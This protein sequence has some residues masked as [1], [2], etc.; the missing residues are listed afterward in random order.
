[1]RKST[2]TTTVVGGDVAGLA[3]ARKRKR[4]ATDHEV[5]VWGPVPTASKVL[6]GPISY[7]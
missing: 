2:I 3:A 1:M 4:A 6:N 5:T 7:S